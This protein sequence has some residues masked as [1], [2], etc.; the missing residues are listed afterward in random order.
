MRNVITG[1]SRLEKG[2]LDEVFE[3]LS[4]RTR[5]FRFVH[6]LERVTVSAVELLLRDAGIHFP[7]ADDSIGLYL[8]IDNAI[9]DIKDEFFHNVL[10]DGLIGASPLLFPFTS[11]NAL[12]A[13]ATIAFDL[14]GES[15]VL[16]VSTSLNSAVEYADEC[17][18][19]GHV[20]M[21]IAGGVISAGEKSEDG[22]HDY[23]ADFIMIES[24]ASAGKRG[25][26]VYDHVPE[27]TA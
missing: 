10:K 23:R 1:K 26:R 27:V 13:Q 5:T 2:K 21:A 18:A 19:A 6:D 9:E 25:A 11:P 4:E 8:G 17:I 14:R 3:T 12:A 15:V 22:L 16:P 20:H 7:V 24:P